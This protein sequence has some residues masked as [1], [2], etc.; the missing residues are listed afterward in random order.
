MVTSPWPPLA[1]YSTIVTPCYK[2]QT[3]ALNTHHE[4]REEQ[5]EVDS[6]RGRQRVPINRLRA[7]AQKKNG[8]PPRSIPV[9]AAGS[10]SGPP[11]LLGMFAGAL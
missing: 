7:L 5:N 10:P 11:N 3:G 1:S 6:E 9:L 8:G 4:W 2:P